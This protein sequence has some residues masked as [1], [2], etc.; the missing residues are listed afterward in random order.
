MSLATTL[1][2]FADIVNEFYNVKWVNG[3]LTSAVIAQHALIYGLKSLG[4]GFFYLVSFQWLRDLS[5]LP[6]LAPELNPSSDVSDLVNPSVLSA[7]SLIEGPYSNLFTIFQSPHYVNDQFVAGFL[8]SFFFSLPLSLPHLISIRRLFYQGTIAAAASI[9]GTLMAHSLFLIGVMYGIRFFIIPWFSLEPLNYI[10]GIAAIYIS[11][12]GIVRE[13]NIKLVPLADRYTLTKF[14]I[15]NFVLAWCEETTLFHSIGNLTINAAPTYL[16][17]YPARGCLDSFL[18]HTSYVISFIFGSIFFSALFYYL[19]LRGSE[20]LRSWTGITFPKMT[21]AVNK[22]MTLLILAFGLS[23]LPYYGLDY[24]FGNWLGFLPEDQ[25]YQQTIFSP[26]VIESSARIFKESPPP[27]KEGRVSTPFNLDL[28]YFDQGLYLNAPFDEKNPPRSGIPNLSFEELNYQGEYAWIMRADSSNYLIETRKS[29]FSFLFKKQRK[30][31]VKLRTS[32]DDK[33]EEANKKALRKKQ[34]GKIAKQKEGTIPGENGKNLFHLPDFLGRGFLLPK[35]VEQGMRH[36]ETPGSYYSDYDDNSFSD[37][38][39]EPKLRK[40]IKEVP[41]YKNVDPLQEDVNLDYEFISDY[42]K[43]FSPPVSITYEDHAKIWIPLKRVIKRRFYL[44][45]VYR[46]LLNLDI[47][48]FLG[49]QKKAYKLAANQEH[50]LYQKRQMLAKYYNWLRYYQPFQRTVQLRYEIPESRSFVDRIYHQQFKGTLKVARRL[51]SVTFDPQKN[52]KNNRVLTYD[53]PLYKDSHGSE[54]PF[55]H[56]ELEDDN[57]DNELQKIHVD[58]DQSELEHE[59]EYDAE[60]NNKQI[61]LK[62]SPFI[63]ET[64]SSPTYAGWDENLRKFV[65]TNRFVSNTPE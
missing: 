35:D 9:T 27:T 48:S 64:S 16:D 24:L 54:N 63:E 58:E 21:R 36:F 10:I 50:S 55:I 53:Q 38:D 37:S 52:A 28:N 1:K 2:D 25:I 47:D 4:G 51:F 33:R 39:S 15:L 34:I 43:G 56:E 6:L 19:I 13:K 17:I 40:M 30:H 18:I 20:L 23:S 46:S 11:I 32:Y 5:Y 62:N 61:D 31:Y 12:N 8:N 59:N 65:V 22:V 41:K 14:L 57:D 44:N 29:F 3:D 60:L 49:R 45:P 7:G 26:T 42:S